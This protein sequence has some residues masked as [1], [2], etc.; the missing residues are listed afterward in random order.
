LNTTYRR[1]IELLRTYRKFMVSRQ[2]AAHIQRMEEDAK[3]FSK[4]HSLN[5]DKLLLSVCAHD[6]FRDVDPRILLK[7]ATLWNLFITKEEE[8]FPILLHGK[9]A[10]EFLKRRFEIK[11]MEILEA[12]AYHTSGIPTNSKI[13]KALVILDTIEHGREFPGVNELRKIA[14]KSLE[15]GYEAIVKNK[16]KYALDNDLIILSESVKTWNYLKGVEDEVS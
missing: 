6:L 5:V 1:V 16:I 8:H 13:V 11:D 14:K 3:N 7:I 12:V 9:V 15:K 4:I 2:R 10:A